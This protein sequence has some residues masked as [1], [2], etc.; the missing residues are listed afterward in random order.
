[1]FYAQEQWTLGP[2]TVQGALRFDYAR[3]YFPEQTVGAQPF[4]PTSVTY[5]STDGVTGYK[6]VAPRGG[7]AWD[8]FGTGKTSI[9]INAGKYVEAAQNDQNYIGS[10][11]TGRVR[12]TTTRSWTDSNNNFVP[13]CDLLNPL[14]QNL[15]TGGGDVC[16]QIGDLSFGKAV[17]D[18]TQDPA[19]LSGWGIRPFVWGYGASVQQQILPRVSV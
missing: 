5:P 14:A 8:V 19:I 13:D 15:S 3:S 7:V 17:F 4:L 10:R 2:V 16:G 18:T 1:A 11:P 12:T 6:D 9:K